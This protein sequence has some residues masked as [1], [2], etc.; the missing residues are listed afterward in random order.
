[1]VEFINNIDEL[2][3]VSQRDVIKRDSRG[4]LVSYT[5]AELSYFADMEYGISHGKSC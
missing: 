3:L 1:M 2:D 5:I 4:A